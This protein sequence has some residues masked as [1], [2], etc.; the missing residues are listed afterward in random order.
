MPSQLVNPRLIQMG[1]GFDTGRVV[2]QFDEKPQVVL[3]PVG[4]ARD[5]EVVQVSMVIFE[6]LPA[7]LLEVRGGDD[8]F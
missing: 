3:Q 5:G 6:H 7:V 8:T 1:N 2:A 4:S